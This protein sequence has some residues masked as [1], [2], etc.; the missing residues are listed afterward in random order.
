MGDVI[1][2]NVLKSGILQQELISRG[3]Q[4]LWALSA[5]ALSFSQP[6]SGHFSPLF[7]GNKPSTLVNT[8]L[9]GF[10]LIC[11]NTHTC[12]FACLESFAH[13]SLGGFVSWLSICSLPVLGIP[14][15]LYS[16]SVKVIGFCVNYPR[17][18]MSSVIFGGLKGCPTKSQ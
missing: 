18:S 2:Q 11:A 15:L 16:L 14:C 7:D 13:F 1:L 9:R 4:S 6:R 12:A 17:G 8:A 3:R 5:A 10:S